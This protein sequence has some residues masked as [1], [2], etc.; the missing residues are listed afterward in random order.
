MSSPIYA[1]L[2][3]AQLVCYS[4]ALVGWLSGGR[5]RRRLVFV[6]FYF[7]LINIAA[8]AA[9]VGFLRGERQVVWTPRKGA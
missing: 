5:V 8:G 2:F 4:L 3:G 9:L 7:S 6:P 1:G